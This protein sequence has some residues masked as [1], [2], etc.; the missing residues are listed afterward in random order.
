MKKMNKYNLS[1]LAYIELKGQI[2]AKEISKHLDLDKARVY[3]ALTELKKQKYI[4][5]IGKYPK[6]YKTNEKEL[7]RII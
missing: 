6:L 3:K 7:K 4:L 1:I 5:E 2:E